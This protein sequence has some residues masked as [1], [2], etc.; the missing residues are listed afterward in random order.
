MKTFCTC[1][2]LFQSAYQHNLV[3]KPGCSNLKDGLR[4]GTEIECFQD[5]YMKVCRVSCSAGLILASL[6][7]HDPLYE[8]GIYTQYQWVVKDS[9][10]QQF[11][12]PF[13]SGTHNYLLYSKSYNILYNMLNVSYI[14]SGHH[15][16]LY[17]LVFAIFI[18]AKV[19]R[20]YKHLLSLIC[21]YV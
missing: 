16:N 1:I 3:I 13:C 20:L 6:L 11:R 18:M 7:D 5:S 19:K 14:F 10:A 4:V 15:A 8:C 9:R 21:T 17:V 12:L 2:I